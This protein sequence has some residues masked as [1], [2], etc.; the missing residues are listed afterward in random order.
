MARMID[1]LLKGYSDYLRANVPKCAYAYESPARIFLRWLASKNMPLAGVT[2]QQF[3]G[4]LCHRRST[5]RGAHTVKNDL[6][7]LRYF[8]R[9]ARNRRL[10]TH[11][12]TKDVSCRWLGIPGG[13]P[14]YQGVLAQALHSHPSF[15][16]DF[17][18]PLFGQDWEGFLR[19]LIDQ[20]Y[21]KRSI[22][23]IALYNRDFHRFLT[24]RKVRG[25]EQIR[26]AHLDAFLRR[27]SV[28][29]RRRHGRQPGRQFINHHRAPIELFLKFAF[30]RRS[31]T[32]GR[33]R[34]RPKS[35]AL[36][37]DLLRRYLNYCRN[38]R[39]LKPIT[40]KYHLYELTKLRR[41]LGRRR[42][43]SV[44]AASISDYD[45]FLL[46]CSKSLS[47]KSLFTLLGVLRG[48][49]R[50]LYV[51]G[52]I[53]S[54][55]ARD[56]IAPRRF[57]ADL[58]PKHLPWRKIEQLLTG[59]ERDTVVGKRDHAILTLLAYHGL[60]ARE[61]AKLAHSD[62]DWEASSLLLRDQKN[63]ATSRIP[64]SPQANAALKS[65]LPVRPDCSCPEIFLT[66]H[67]PLK[68]LG[69]NLSSVARFHL[70]KRFGRLLPSQGSH[71]LR[72]SFAKL[73]LDRRAKLEDV[74]ILLRHKSPN[75]AQPYTRI[76]VEDL[77]EVADNYANLLAGQPTNASSVAVTLP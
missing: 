37:D 22:R 74:R 48:F 49:L 57:S 20:R 75:S 21:L 1:D 33:V 60:R 41:F 19:Q 52:M 11:D 68:P 34:A 14:G 51:E 47:P 64:L 6:V 30:S 10:I 65:Y 8:F 39:G 3:N 63:G 53:T 9:Y 69:A 42:I 50:Y 62:I 66:A 24:F 29:Y 5:G 13:Y 7:K 15:L 12:P 46:E 16:F 76:A 28:R 31:L 27:V 61:V 38:H 18:L 32:F 43:K 59:I 56:L 25:V 2:A 77:R 67:A 40:L 58:R 35:G 44:A 73:L 17:R 36:P 23:A 54:D 4:Y 71:L 72:H 26:P 45:K 70:N 55:L